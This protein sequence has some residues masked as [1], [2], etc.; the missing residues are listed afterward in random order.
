MSPRIL[1]AKILV[2]YYAIIQRLELTL[3]FQMIGSEKQCSLEV[4]VVVL[5]IPLTM[6]MHPQAQG[7]LESAS[8]R[9]FHISVI[10]YFNKKIS[11]SIFH[12]F[13]CSLMCCEK[14]L[15]DIRNK[16]PFWFSIAPLFLSL[17]LTFVSMVFSSFSSTTSCE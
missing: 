17:F 12:V 9:G 15:N 6:Y 14:K 5:C 4:I 1:K 8:L 3:T 2:F 16:I 11:L 10:Y 7:D 13:K